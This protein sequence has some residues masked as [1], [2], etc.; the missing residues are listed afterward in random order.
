[1]NPRL[2]L[3]TVLVSVSPVL[4]AQDLP[5]K[6]AAV[7]KDYESRAAKLNQE[8][9]RLLDAEMQAATRSGNLEAVSAIAKKIAVLQNVATRPGESPSEAF[10]RRATRKTWTLQGTVKLK[11]V[12]FDGKELRPVSDSGKAGAAF[13][14][15]IE[16]PGVMSIRTSEGEQFWFVFSADLSSCRAF[17]AEKIYPGKVVSK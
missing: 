14:T 6:A 10:V 11:R 13:R 4:W 2:L 17:Y 8:Y 15:Q 16:A 3:F 9:A 7:M 5:P 1:M 12:T